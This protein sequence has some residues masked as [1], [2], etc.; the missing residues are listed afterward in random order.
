MQVWPKRIQGTERGHL[1]PRALCSVPP[2][3]GW[4]HPQETCRFYYFLIVGQSGI[5][6]CTK[7]V[8]QGSKHEK[9]LEEAPAN[10]VKNCP[11]PKFSLEAAVRPLGVSRG[12]GHHLPQMK[13]QGPVCGM[14]SGEPRRTGPEREPRCAV[15]GDKGIRRSWGPQAPAQRA[16]P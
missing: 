7:N 5:G 9:P 1:S 15:T 8:K 4:G 10:V 2:S 11:F 16:L 6:L 3:A 13:P 14:G 12:D